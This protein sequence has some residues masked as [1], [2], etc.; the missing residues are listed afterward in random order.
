LESL[1]DG[2]EILLTLVYKEFIP[3]RDRAALAKGL[4]G[5]EFLLCGSRV[6]GLEGLAKFLQIRLSGLKVLLYLL[7]K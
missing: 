3:A 1:T 4:D 5:A 7:G 2:V 6:S